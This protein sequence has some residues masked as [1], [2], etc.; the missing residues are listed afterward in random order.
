MNRMAGSRV[1]STEG[2]ALSMGIIFPIIKMSVGLLPVLPAGGMDV[3]AQLTGNKHRFCP[4]APR[5][6]KVDGMGRAVAYQAA[7]CE[8]VAEGNF[9]WRGSGCDVAVNFFICGTFRRFPV[10][11]HFGEQRALLKKAV[12]PPK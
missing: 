10:V 2:G 12:A 9:F 1:G 7:A 5:A 6:S 8:Y 3:R 11:R 4:F